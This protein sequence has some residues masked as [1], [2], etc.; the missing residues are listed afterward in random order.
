MLRRLVKLL[1]LPLLALPLAAGCRGTAARESAAPP[2]KTG[3]ADLRPKLAVAAD[4]AARHAA[5]GLLFPASLGL[6]PRVET[7]VYDDAG[8]DVSAGYDLFP[9]FAAVTLYVYP[10]PAG[11]TV[12]QAF[13]EAKV[14]LALAHTDWRAVGGETAAAGRLLGGAAGAP[15]YQSVYR[16]DRPDP[17]F[18]VPVESVLALAQLAR[19]GDD[20]RSYLV[21]VRATYPAERADEARAAL[22]E[23]LRDWR[24]AN[25][26][27]QPAA[28]TT[29]AADDL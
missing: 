14:E 28:T 7:S 5:T 3:P 1:A 16:G 19:P 4:R 2:V 17:A 29:R 10:L 15:V 23:L 26:L 18:N 24:S 8:R 9:S 21:S 12:E 27:P 11:E 20:G 22:G 6:S 13:D 25:D